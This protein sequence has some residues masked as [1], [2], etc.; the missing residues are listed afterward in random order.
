MSGNLREAPVTPLSIVPSEGSVRPFVVGIGGTTRANSSSE[1]A[2]RAVLAAAEAAGATTEHFG[3]DRIELPMYAPE[4]P[5][6]TEAA[7]DLVD[8]IRRADGLVIASPGYHGGVSG[9]VKNALDYVEDLRDDPRPYLDGRAVGC[10][11]CAY[12]W[13][14]TTTTLVALRSI[15]HALRG[16]PTPLGIAM[17]SAEP[18]FADDGAIQHAGAAAQVALLGDQIVQFATAFAASR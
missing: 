8:A 6:R 14:A 4:R 15:V 16:W 10:I 3:A 2:V 11:A 1:K 13:Q 7:T 18:V 17:N 12:G 9:L 5:G